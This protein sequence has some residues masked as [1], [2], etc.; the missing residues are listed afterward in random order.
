MMTVTGADAPNDGSAPTTG[1]GPGGAGVTGLGPRRASTL[2]GTQ[3]GSSGTVT[4]RGSLEGREASAPAAGDTGPDP[5]GVSDIKAGPEPSGTVTRRAS[6]AEVKALDAK[7]DYKYEFDAELVMI[8]AVT[9]VTKLYLNHHAYTG[10]GECYNLL[11]AEL[12]LLQKDNWTTASATSK[13]TDNKLQRAREVIKAAQILAEKEVRSLKNPGHTTHLHKELEDLFQACLGKTPLSDYIQKRINAELLPELRA[14]ETLSKQNSDLKQL[15]ADLTAKLA[16]FTGESKKSEDTG[17]DLDSAVGTRSNKKQN[18]AYYLRKNKHA[19]EGKLPNAI[20][21]RNPKVAK[22][23]AAIWLLLEDGISPAD[24]QL[25]INHPDYAS[26]LILRDRLKELLIKQA[27]AEVQKPHD[28]IAIGSPVYNNNTCNQFLARMLREGY[29]FPVNKAEA[30]ALAAWWTNPRLAVL[31]SAKSWSEALAATPIPTRGRSGSYPGAS[32]GLASTAHSSLPS[33]NVPGTPLRVAEIK[34]ASTHLRSGFVSGSQTPSGLGKTSGLG[35]AAG[36]ADFQRKL[37]SLAG[38]EPPPVPV[39][40]RITSMTTPAT[41]L[42]S[43]SSVHSG[44]GSVRVGTEPTPL[45]AE[46]KSVP[47]TSPTPTAPT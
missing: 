6:L 14:N 36:K 40:S 10:T 28:K 22:D 31:G 37:N 15:L 17:A 38:G 12:K 43:L 29:L 16:A 39:F 19:L 44:D 45:I 4:R 35:T 33:P 3:T 46:H 25:D 24:G 26:N 18:A 32:A 9:I 23:I 20:C 30:D 42:G 8:L 21:D 2:G 5:R 41:S 27:A 34:L 47:G 7:L 11:D 13:I 1:P